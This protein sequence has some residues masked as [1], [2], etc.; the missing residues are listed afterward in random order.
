MIPVTS[1]AVGVAY[2][3]LSADNT[4]SHRYLYS[5]QSRQPSL[6][7]SHSLWKFNTILKDQVS[8]ADSDLAVRGHYTGQP[9]MQG[10][11]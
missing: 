3:C 4:L 7:I 6:A 9:G 5:F 1:S 10:E 2:L 8:R 11:L